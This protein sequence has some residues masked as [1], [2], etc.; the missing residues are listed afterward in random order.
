MGIT[1]VT[2]GGGSFAK[3]S[4]RKSSSEVLKEARMAPYWEYAND[5]LVNRIFKEFSSE[6]VVHLD[7]PDEKFMFPRRRM[8]SLV[9]ITVI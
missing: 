8:Y 5:I 4:F 7:S 1:A 9:L 3:I 6:K 2:N